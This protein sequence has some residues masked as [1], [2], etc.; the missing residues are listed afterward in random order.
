M[1]LDHATDF[2]HDLNVPISGLDSRNRRRSNSVSVNVGD[3]D[4]RQMAKQ[5][6]QGWD[7]KRDRS[8]PSVIEPRMSNGA[9]GLQNIPGPSRL[10]EPLVGNL[11]QAP[12]YTSILRTRI[13]STG[14]ILEAHNHDGPDGERSVL[15]FV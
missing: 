14:E 11:L 15:L 9:L 12:P 1:D 2:D 7:Y 4:E 8:M 6:M 3:V 13:E 5:R 10:I